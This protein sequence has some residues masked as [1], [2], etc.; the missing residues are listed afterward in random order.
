MQAVAQS[1]S[2]N[3]MIYWSVSTVI[4]VDTVT[5]PPANISTIGPTRQGHRNVRVQTETGRKIEEHTEEGVA[6][7][8]EKR[9]DSKVNLAERSQ[10][11]ALFQGL[12]MTFLVSLRDWVTVPLKV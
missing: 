7:T 5:L 12:D 10:N 8:T 1:P 9:A 2:S 6:L 11:H 4:G 3:G